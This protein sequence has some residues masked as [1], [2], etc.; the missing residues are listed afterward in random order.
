MNQQD[1][2]A[3]KKDLKNELRRFATKDDLEDHKDEINA[4][5]TSFKSEIIDHADAVMG[6]IKAIRE[7]LA[8]HTLSHTRID[9]Q[10]DNHTDRLEK[11]EKP[12]LN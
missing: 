7:D 5:M 6:E 1:Q 12:H 2:P 10:L 8:A 3:T 9:D 4:K 11:L